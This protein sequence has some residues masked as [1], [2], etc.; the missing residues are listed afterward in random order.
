MI[1]NPAKIISEISQTANGFRSSIVIH[2]DTK[3]ID[4]KSILGLF[5]TLTGKQTYRLEVSGE[6]KVAAEKAMIDI[7]QKNNLTIEL[8]N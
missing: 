4:A 5:T 1:T 7:F 8:I 3:H 2:V 6:D